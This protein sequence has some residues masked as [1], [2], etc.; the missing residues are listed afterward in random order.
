M[1]IKD[2]SKKMS[3]SL[4][5]EYCIYLDESLE[6]LTEKVMKSPTTPE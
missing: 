5:D 2:P 6:T 3:K 4:G 1:S